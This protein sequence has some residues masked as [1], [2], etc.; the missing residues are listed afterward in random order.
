MKNSFGV[1]THRMIW[2]GLVAWVPPCLDAAELRDGDIVFQRCQSSQAEAIAA[3]TK[4]Y[5]THVGIVFFTNNRPFVYEAIQPVSRTPLNEWTQRGLGG[6][7]VVKRLKK[8]SN[9][10]MSKVKNE[11]QRLMG[12]DYDLLFEWS[13]NR[14]YC[15]ELV[16]KAYD[17]GAMVKIG[18]LKKLR[19]F[20]LSSPHVRRIMRE[21]YGETIPL[22]MDVIAPSEMFNCNELL[23]VLV[24]DAK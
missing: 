22:D 12:R 24:V 14:I 8:S 13:D 20:D 19:D 16:W 7:Y 1:A 23:T 10:D 18:A 2:L 17:R 11:V 3:A 15:S 9:I 6:H 5:Y 4:S 21:R